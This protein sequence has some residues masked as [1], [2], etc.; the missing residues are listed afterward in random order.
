MST[1]EICLTIAAI[2]AGTMLSRG[3]P[4]VLFSRVKKT[5]PY[6]GYLG[7]TLPPAAIGLLIVYCF[8]DVSFTEKP[9]GAPEIT[10]SIAAALIQVLFRHT[11]L[12][13]VMSTALYMLLIRI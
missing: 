9:Y 8:K 7:R 3:L 10:A 13:I 11:L 4:F 1:V 12:S 2:A 5:P 6:V